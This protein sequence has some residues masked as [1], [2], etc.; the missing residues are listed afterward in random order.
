MWIWL[1]DFIPQQPPSQPCGMCERGDYD[2]EMQDYVR[3]FIHAFCIRYRGYTVSVKQQ[4][5]RTFDA[6]K[7]IGV[8]VRFVGLKAGKRT[9]VHV[10]VLLQSFSAVQ[11]FPH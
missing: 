7:Q 6:L 8:C 9:T 11:R 1:K 2:T 10:V 4:E 3:F 5:K